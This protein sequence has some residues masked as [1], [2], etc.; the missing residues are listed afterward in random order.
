MMNTMYSTGA[1]SGFFFLGGFH[2]LATIAFLIGLLF[3]IFWAQKTLTA[4]QL[5]QWGWILAVGGAVVSL[6]V[7]GGI[8][9]SWSGEMGSGK[10]MEY[11]MGDH[12]MGMMDDDDDAMGMSMNGMSRMLE[13]KSGDEFDAAFIEMMIPHHQ[14]AIDMAEL[15]QKNAGHAEIKAMADAIIE[16]QQ[17]EIDQMKGWQ[18]AWGFTK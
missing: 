9:N 14:G 2:F 15:A 10:S 18:N 11:Q 7:I 12:M 8:T 5:M 4:K 16:A 1:T 6:L 13:G 17:R 3:L